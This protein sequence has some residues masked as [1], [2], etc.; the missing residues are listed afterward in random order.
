VYGI[1]NVILGAVIYL[2]MLMYSPTSTVFSFF[3]AFC[4]TL[5]GIYI[6]FFLYKNMCKKEKERE[7]KREDMRGSLILF[8]VY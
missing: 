3:G 5:A 6:I 1:D 8:T 4:G 7:K 2:A